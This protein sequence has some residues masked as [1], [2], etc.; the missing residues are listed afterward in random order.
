MEKIGGYNLVEIDSTKINDTEYAKILFKELEE[1]TKYGKPLHVIFDNYTESEVAYNVD[2]HIE[3]KNISFGI[4]IDDGVFN[5]SVTHDEKRDTYV[6]ALSDMRP[7][8]CSMTSRVDLDIAENTVQT[9]LDSAKVNFGRNIVLNFRQG[10]YYQNT[11]VI[12]K[13]TRI[14]ALSI[15]KLHKVFKFMYDSNGKVYFITMTVNNQMAT[16][17]T[18]VI[19]NV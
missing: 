19:S 4:V 6:Y 2:Y 9:T 3:R 11:E 13:D 16:F 18:V 12:P 15:D 17:S 8:Y 14:T 7:Y 5:V 1:K 10:A